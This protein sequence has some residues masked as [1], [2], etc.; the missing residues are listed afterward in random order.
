MYFSCRVWDVKILKLRLSLFPISIKHPIFGR[1]V[2]LYFNLISFLYTD[3][4][5]ALFMALSFL[6]LFSWTCTTNSLGR[7]TLR[8]SYWYEWDMMLFFCLSRRK[9]KR[10]CFNWL[11]YVSTRTQKKTPILKITFANKGIVA[12]NISNM[13]NQKSVQSHIP[14]TFK[15][16][17]RMHF[18]KLYW[19]S[20]FQ[21]F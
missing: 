7:V 16:R 10:V 15:T 21:N 4:Q 9:G 3:L 2:T 18:K 20:C 12:L 11:G 19:L 5:K 17:S 14:H 8:V 6:G 1:R 13:L